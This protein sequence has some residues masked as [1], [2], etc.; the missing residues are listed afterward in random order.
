MWRNLKTICLISIIVFTIILIVGEMSA[1]QCVPKQVAVIGGG[2][3]GIS[4][5]YY[6]NKLTCLEVELFEKRTRLGGRIQT[7]QSLYSGRRKGT[8]R[9]GH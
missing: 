9:Y 8:R 7:G 4:T 2:L 5:V 6:L 1:K 3:A